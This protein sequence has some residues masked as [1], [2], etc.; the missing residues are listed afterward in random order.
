MT[1]ATELTTLASTKAAIK[2]AIEAKGQDLTGI[3]FAGYAPKIEAISGSAEP[4]PYVRPTDW[5]A[6]PDVTGQQKFV[7]LHAVYPDSNFCALLAEGGY[8]VDWGD[9]TVE[10]IASGVQANHQY[11]YSTF[12]VANA[13]LCSRG[14][15]QAIVTVTPQAGQNL[16]TLNLHK[17]HTMAGLQMY[18]SGFLDIAISG[19]LLTSLLIGVQTAGADTQVISFTG[20]EQV[21]LL[22][23]AVT[24]FSYMFN[25]CSSLQS[26]P[27]LDTSAGTNFSYMFQSCSSLQSIPLLDTSAGTDFS[28]MFYK[29][30][31]LQSIPL[32][33]TSAGTT[34]SYMFYACTSLQS[35]PL[36]DTSA[37]TTF[38]YMFYACYSLQSIP[39]LDTSAGTNF[40]YMFDNC[41]SLQSIPLLDTSAGTTFSFMFRNCISLQSIP[42]L[43]TSAGTDFSY[44]LYVCYHLQSIPL[45][46]TSAGTNFL[47]MFSTCSSLS[48]AAL[49]GTK[50][51]ISYINCKLSADALNTIYTNLATVTGQTITVTGN[52]GVASDNPTIATAKGWTVTG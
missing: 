7:G 38:S 30:S 47:H 19:S 29:C 5:L 13:T 23:N 46:D 24:T 15:K 14:Y 44:M 31:S 26:I 41:T 42:L 1:I 18:S 36:L 22:D 34:F 52:W 25:K 35:I 37:V 10:N 17:K 32:L 12:D 8:T 39:L 51:S 50:V 6:L 2:A 9:G 3:N 20:L 21:T 28:G 16:T 4:T 49:S 11:N 27:L 45:L 40:S 33:D 43:D 48:Q